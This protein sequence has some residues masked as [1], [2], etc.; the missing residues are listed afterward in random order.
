MAKTTN[1]FDQQLAIIESANEAMEDAST[2]DPAEKN[3]AVELTEEQKATKAT[4]L[5]EKFDARVVER[6][7]EHVPAYNADYH[8]KS[9]ELVFFDI[10]DCDADLIICAAVPNAPQLTATATESRGGSARL[11]DEIDA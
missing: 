10:E 6:R 2:F 7:R 4:K 5:R 8:K 3:D 1:I 11:N 9:G